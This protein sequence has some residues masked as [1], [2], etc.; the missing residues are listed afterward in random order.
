MLA[1]ITYQDNF[2]GQECVETL[3]VASFTGEAI[4]ACMQERMQDETGLKHTY[5]CKLFAI[6]TTVQET[7]VFH[8]IYTD[9]DGYTT[10]DLSGYAVL[11]AY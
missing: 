8:I 4:A 11:L 6:T 9:V 3:N 2:A 10:S 5:A 7:A 1:K